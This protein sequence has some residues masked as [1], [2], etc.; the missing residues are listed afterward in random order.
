MITFRIC[1]S[2]QMILVV[3]IGYTPSLVVIAT[4]V[5]QEWYSLSASLRLRN[6]LIFSIYYIL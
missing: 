4:F 3:D 5:L 1:A 2:T 6:S